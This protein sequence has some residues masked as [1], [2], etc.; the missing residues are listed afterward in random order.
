MRKKPLIFR[1]RQPQT[2]GLISFGLPTK[3]KRTLSVLGQALEREKLSKQVKAD[4]RIR[5]SLK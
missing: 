5:K 3:Q 2:P 1:I 4:V